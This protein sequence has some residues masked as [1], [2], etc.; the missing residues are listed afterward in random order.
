M[1]SK[2]GSSCDPF[3]LSVISCSVNEKNRRKA[4]FFGFVELE[5]FETSWQSYRSYPVT[6]P[7]YLC[8]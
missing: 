7:T 8:N 4:G 5:L 1:S 2:K 3:Y 6:T